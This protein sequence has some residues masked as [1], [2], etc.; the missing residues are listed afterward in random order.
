MSFM[1]TLDTSLG[2]VAGDPERIL[3]AL[4]IGISNFTINEITVC[5]NEI[6]NM[7]TILVGKVRTLLSEYDDASEVQINRG[8]ADDAG[9]VLIKADVLEWQVMPGGSYEAVIKEKGRVYDE[10]LKI[11]SFCPCI[12]TDLSKYSTSLIRS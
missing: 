4:Q 3:L 5:C 12:G 9:R 2:W 8:V 7:S 1:A 10:L 6:G 11:F